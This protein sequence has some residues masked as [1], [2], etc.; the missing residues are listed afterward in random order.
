MSSSRRVMLEH[1]YSISFD[2]D[3]SL[4][5]CSNSDFNIPLHQKVAKLETDC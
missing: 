4:I 1:N 3:T 5:G 2:D